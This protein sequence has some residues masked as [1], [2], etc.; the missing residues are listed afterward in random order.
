M[1]GG[2]GGGN[3]NTST[4]RA[5]TLPGGFQPRTSFTVVV[6]IVGHASLSLPCVVSFYGEIY[7]QVC[8]EQIALQAYKRS[9]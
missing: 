6:Y 1:G 3:H 2:G 9:C 8:G 5:S 4:G 7:K